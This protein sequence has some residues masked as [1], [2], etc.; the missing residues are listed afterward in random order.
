VALEEEKAWL[1]AELAGG[2]N[3]KGVDETMDDVNEDVVMGVAEDGDENDTGIECQCC[4]ADYPFVRTFLLSP[5]YLVLTSRPTVPNGSM[6]RSSPLL[7]DL[8]LNLRIHPTRLSQL[9]S[10]LYPPFLM[11]STLPH[12]GTQT[13]PLSQIV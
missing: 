5:F 12:F 2:G 4:F 3:A 1:D 6:P 10:D 13:N 7:L 11:F 8:Y 9:L